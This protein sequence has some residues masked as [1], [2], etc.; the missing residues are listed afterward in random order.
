MKKPLIII[1]AA[2]ALLVTAL[3]A[4]WAKNFYITLLISGYSTSDVKIID[5]SHNENDKEFKVIKTSSKD[6]SDALAILTKNSLGIWSITQKQENIESRPIT[7]IGWVNKGEVKRYTF[8]DGGVIEN[9]W[10][11]VYCGNNA[12]KLIQFNPGQ[13]PENVTVNIQQNGSSYLIHLISF[14]DSNTVSKFDVPAILTD[15]GC[16]SLE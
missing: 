9:E 11:I 13:I 7:T 4:A 6:K 12:I 16:L 5:T 15:N 2:A 14:A 10:N 8:K 1:L 3:S